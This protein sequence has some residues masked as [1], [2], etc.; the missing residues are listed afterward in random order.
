MKAPNPGASLKADLKQGCGELSSSPW[1]SLPP[2]KGHLSLLWHACGAHML[3]SLHTSP[4]PACGACMLLSPVMT[5]IP[6][7]LIQKLETLSGTPW[8]AEKTIW[9]NKNSLLFEIRYI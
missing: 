4:W 3:L 2:P 7:G 6:R 1:H 8:A 5:K 9:Q